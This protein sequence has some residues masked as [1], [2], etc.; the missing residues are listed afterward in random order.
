MLR[1]QA[2]DLLL[3]GGEGA[4][5]DSGGEQESGQQQP[6]CDYER[7]ERECWCWLEVG[8]RTASPARC[9]LCFISVAP[10]GPASLHSVLYSVSRCVRP[11]TWMEKIN[12]YL[13]DLIDV[14]SVRNGNGP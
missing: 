13:D 3:L 10:A 1:L 6:H 12:L 8:V 5:E 9:A 7:R 4:G 2:G 14:F 11:S